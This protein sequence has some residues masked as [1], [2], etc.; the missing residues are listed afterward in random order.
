MPDVAVAVLA[1]APIPGFAKTRLIGLLGAEGAAR[2][3][4]RL[5]ERALATATTAAMGPVT[6]WCTPD[7]GHTT[8]QDAAE[9]YG[10]KLAVQPAGDLG[11]R[12][13]AAFRHASGK[14]GVVLI[15]TDCPVLTPGDLQDAARALADADAVV[16]PAED[17]GYG[18]IAARRP[19]PELFD[20]MPWGTDA[21][22]ASTRE[23][24]QRFSLRLAELRTVWDIDTPSDYQRFAAMPWSGDLAEVATSSNA[25]G[26]RGAGQAT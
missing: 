15:G 18:L 4:A 22:A 2:L 13:L 11:A 21:V 12:M 3:Q 23:R 26:Q 17:G 24:A 10:I 20:D 25:S 14:R 16:A 8:F 19:I 5:I 1:K 6:L 7:L 9:R